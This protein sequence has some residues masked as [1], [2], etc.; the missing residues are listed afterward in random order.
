MFTYDLNQ[1]TGIAD[2]SAPP[3]ATAVLAAAQPNPF[4]AATTFEARLATGADEAR[5][6]IY[7]A[8]GRSVATLTDGP[9]A[10]GRHRLQ[11]D[12]RTTGGEPAPAGVYFA[13]LNVGNRVSIQ[14]V[15][16]LP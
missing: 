4:A 1:M 14:K 16:R 15:V 5:L 7:D 12:G 13:R 6:T 2:G 8:L 3:G 11:W 9:L 10:A